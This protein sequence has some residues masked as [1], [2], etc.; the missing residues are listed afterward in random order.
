[1]KYVFQSGF[2]QDIEGMLRFKES[3]GHRA[4]S[5]LSNLRQFDRLLCRVIPGDLPADQSHGR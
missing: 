2:A 5:Y 1:M 4:E 3:L